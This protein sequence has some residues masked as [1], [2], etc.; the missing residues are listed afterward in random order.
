MWVTNNIK[1]QQNKNLLIKGFKK[2]RPAESL[3][4]FITYK[5]V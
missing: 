2:K 1:K 3:A 5:I 4:K